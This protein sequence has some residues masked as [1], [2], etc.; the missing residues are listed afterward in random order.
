M[1]FHYVISM[2]KFIKWSK[3]MDFKLN[4]SC[5]CHSRTRTQTWIEMETDSPVVAPKCVNVISSF[6]DPY[7]KTTVLEQTKKMKDSKTLMV[8]A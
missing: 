5:Q 3:L 6:Q 1:H 7:K 8:E 2:E 4:K